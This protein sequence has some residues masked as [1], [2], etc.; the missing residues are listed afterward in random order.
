MFLFQIGTIKTLSKIYINIIQNS[1]CYCQVKFTFNEILHSVAVEP[2]SCKFTGRLT[3]VDREWI[4]HH[5]L[6]I[7]DYLNGKIIT[8]FQRSTAEDINIIPNNPLSKAGLSLDSYLHPLP[9]L[10]SILHHGVELN[11]WHAIFF[12]AK[13]LNSFV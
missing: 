2:Q 10:S 3:A 12:C 13:K 5:N 1:Y 9:L 6:A 4:H 7:F 11:M 8:K